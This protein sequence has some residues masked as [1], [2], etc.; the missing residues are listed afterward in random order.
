MLDYAKLA[1]YV[2]QLVNQAVTWLREQN[3]IDA[4]MDK[5]IA[6][7]SLAIAT[8]TKFAKEILQSISALNESQT[9]DVLKQLES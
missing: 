8:K 3:L 5:A 1:L 7:E 2:L 9:D 6:Q 4:G